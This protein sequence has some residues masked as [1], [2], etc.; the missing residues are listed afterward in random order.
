MIEQELMSFYKSEKFKAEQDEWYRKL[1]E[2]GFE[3]IEFE[4]KD[5]RGGS[6]KRFHSKF[7]VSRFKEGLPQA[8]EDYYRACAEFMLCHKFKDTREQRIWELHCDGMSVRKI[9]V[10]I[11]WHK[12]LV[13]RTIMALEDIMWGG[14]GNGV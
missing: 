7:F 3:D 11:D 6:L 4:F 1:K 9:A 8:K 5:G 10:E 14:I 2:E 13:N 12:D